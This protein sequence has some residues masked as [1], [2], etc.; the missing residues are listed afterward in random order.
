[1]KITHDKIASIKGNLFY[2]SRDIVSNYDEFPWHVYHNNVDTDKV[3]SSQAL[4]IDFWGCL[5]SSEFKNELINNFF[6]KSANDWVIELEY[7]DS[8]LLNEPTSTQIDVL[9]K[10]SECVIFIESKFTEQGGKCSQPN[11]KCNGNYQLQTNPENGIESK[12]SLT[13][14]KIKYWDYIDKV[15][16]FKKDDEYLPCPF[17]G[18]EYQWMRNICFA[19]AYS[20]H[21]H[22]IQ[23]EAYLFY[24]S[25]SKCHISK[26]VLDGEYL[27]KLKDKLITN[28]KAISYNDYL[29]FCID[30]LKHK[31]NEE[32]KVWLGLKEWL[33]EKE[34]KIKE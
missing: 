26:K 24:Y 1:M 11:K 29:S 2:R 23:A 6:G 34:K 5:N 19:K 22:G 33:I 15:T 20:E 18:I 27:G 12:C 21:N 4:A 16:L 31:D 25:S 30:Y 10:S 13:G 9:L 32:I 7:T 3:Q 28:F 14:K 8:A 17:K